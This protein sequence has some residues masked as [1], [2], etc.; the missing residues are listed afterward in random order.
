M[1]MLL[2]PFLLAFWDISSTC[3]NFLNLRACSLTHLHFEFVILL[4][5]QV[6]GLLLPY[7]K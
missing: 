7:Y 5:F 4:S 3:F 1:D 2:V 6:F